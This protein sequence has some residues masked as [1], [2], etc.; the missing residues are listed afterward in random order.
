M[1]NIF[2]AGPA[3]FLGSYFLYHVLLHSEDIEI[4]FTFTTRAMP[5]FPPLS[6]T[7]LQ[8]HKTLQKI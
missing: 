5:S 2:I 4:A 7:I 8:Q 6:F 1:K 3:G